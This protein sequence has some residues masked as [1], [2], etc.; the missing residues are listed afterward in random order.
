MLEEEAGFQ[1]QRPIKVHDKQKVGFTN[2]VK[3]MELCVNGT[4]A[5]RADEICKC[6]IA[7]GGWLVT[8]ERYGRVNFLPPFTRDDLRVVVRVDRTYSSSDGAFFLYAFT[9][10]VWVCIAALV[11]LFTTLK[12]VDPTFVPHLCRP[13]DTP[14][15]DADVPSCRDSNDTRGVTA[16]RSAVAAWRERFIR[17]A[18]DRPSWAHRSKRFRRATQGVCKFRAIISPLLFV[19]PSVHEIWNEICS[20]HFPL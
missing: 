12:M 11:S 16:F 17:W 9:P 8:T 3:K 7:T 15:L 2:F 5:E 13:M 18:H 20:I 19:Y 14:D 10:S 6:D 4:S 1:C